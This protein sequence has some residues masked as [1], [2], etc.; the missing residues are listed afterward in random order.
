MAV[1]ATLKTDKLRLQESFQ[2]QIVNGWYLDIDTQSSPIKYTL[3]HG[4]KSMSFHSTVT[5]NL[6]TR[7]YGIRLAKGRRQMILPPH[8]LQAFVEHETFLS[9]FDR[10]I[11]TSQ[12]SDPSAHQSEVM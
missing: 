7:N 9:W 3:T 10:S 2:F 6:C 4:K 1:M 8:V 12:C 11:N 5:K